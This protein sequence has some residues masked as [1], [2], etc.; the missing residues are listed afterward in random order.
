MKRLTEQIRLPF[1]PHKPSPKQLLFLATAHLGIDNVF[2]GGEAGG[3]KSDALL[4]NHCQ[5]SHIPDFDSLLLRRTYP[6]LKQPGG[7]IPMSRTWFGGTDVLWNKSDSRWTFP[8]IVT[9][10]PGAPTNRYYRGS[11]LTFGHLQHAK[12]TDNYQGPSFNYIGFDELTHFEKRMFTYLFSRLR[13]PEGQAVAPHMRA[14]GNPGGRGHNWVKDMYIPDPED[15]DAEKALFIPARR[16]DN[17]GLDIEDY[18]RKL[19]M[20]DPLTY[21]QLAEGSW[22][23]TAP[24][25]QFKREK[26]EIVDQAPAEMSRV[27]FWDMAGTEP[28]PVNPDPDW[29]AGC[30]MGIIDGIVFI[31]DMQRIRANPGGVEDLIAQTAQLDGRAFPV[32]TEEEPGSSGKFVSDHFARKV[33]PGWDYRGD[34]ATGNKEVRAKPLAAAVHAGNVKL[35]KGPWNKA[36]LDEITAFPDWDHDDQVDA[37]SGAYQELTAK[38][39]PGLRFF[40]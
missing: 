5:F 40:D 8:G 10:F 35:V 36:F 1:V 31:E 2:Y 9:S 18:E 12:D 15:P 6:Q 22:E 19:A 16:Y 38:G 29:T 20:L 7:L 33:L 32:R 24:G 34:R 27:R 26:F 37:A 25:G 30:R 39:S 21:V 13:G 4:M 3:G 11:T 28:T 23:N 17:P 14:A